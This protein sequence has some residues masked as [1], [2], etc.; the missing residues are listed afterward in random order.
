MRA[1]KDARARRVNDN[2]HVI[3]GEPD[4]VPKEH[5]SLW[6]RRLGV[7]GETAVR[8]A[9]PGGFMARACLPTF[10]RL[11]LL[12]CSW[13]DRIGDRGARAGIVDPA[14]DRH[15]MHLLPPSILGCISPILCSA[16]LTV[17]ACRQTA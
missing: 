4:T 10:D 3:R 12:L 5:R 13:H 17:I 6:P 7:T 9:I 1:A 11:V 16:P 15:P 2:R 8:T 14:A